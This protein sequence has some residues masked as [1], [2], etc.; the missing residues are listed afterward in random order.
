MTHYSVEP[1]D[2]IFVK[3]Y[4][5]YLLLKIW[6]TSQAENTVKNLLI[7]LKSLLH[8]QLKLYQKSKTF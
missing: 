2:G 6:V 5:F 8:V 1:R 4:R 3:G 7:M